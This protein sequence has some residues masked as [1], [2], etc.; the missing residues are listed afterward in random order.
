MVKNGVFGI[1]VNVSEAN[2]AYNPTIEKYMKVKCCI[3]HL[4]LG[5]LR[6]TGINPANNVARLT[7]A[8]T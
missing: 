3:S 2:A 5:F 4:L 6:I 8:A 1:R 7:S